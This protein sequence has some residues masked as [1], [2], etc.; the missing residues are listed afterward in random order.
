MFLWPFNTL[1]TVDSPQNIIIITIVIAIII[2]I[3]IIIV[4]VIVI[5]IVVVFII[6]INYPPGNIS[7]VI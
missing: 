2:I 6:V 7:N 1:F 5:F 4:N 3:I